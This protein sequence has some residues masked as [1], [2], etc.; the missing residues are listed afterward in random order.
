MDELPEG[1]SLPSAETYSPRPS[2]SVMLSK[3]SVSGHEILMGHRISELPAFPDLWS[4]PGGGVSRVDR[5]AADSHPE[6]LSERGRDRLA[7]FTLLREMVE[8][9]GI[10]PNGEGGF[11]EVEQDVR[12]KVCSDKSA[13]MEEVGS[14]RISIEG[15]DCHVITERTLSLIHI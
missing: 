8:E 5:K 3:V 12:D 13:W 11:I 1:L 10:A 15:F 9:V 2:A 4:F 7:A 14:G 6:W